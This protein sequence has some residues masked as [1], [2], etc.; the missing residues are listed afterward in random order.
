MKDNLA[1]RV[2]ESEPSQMLGKF[3]PI[4]VPQ[5]SRIGELLMCICLLPKIFNYNDVLYKLKL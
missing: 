2:L 4:K 3:S 1:E 5:I